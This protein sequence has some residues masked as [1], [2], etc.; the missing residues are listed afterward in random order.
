ML[1]SHRLRIEQDQWLGPWPRDIA[2]GEGRPCGLCAIRGEGSRLPTGPGQLGPPPVVGRRVRVVIADLEAR[3]LHWIPIENTPWRSRR[4]RDCG[5]RGGT[6][7]NSFD[8]STRRRLDC[9]LARFLWR[10][11]DDVDRKDEGAEEQW[12]RGKGGDDS[13]ASLPASP[14]TIDDPLFQLRALVHVLLSAV[15]HVGPCALD[16]ALGRRA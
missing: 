6:R 13:T 10:V 11:F 15:G 2:C 16:R 3:D 8:L 5:S 1:R 14:L 9:L 12:E 4:S 7:L